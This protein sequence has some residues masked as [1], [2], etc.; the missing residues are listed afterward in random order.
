MYDYDF[1]VQAWSKF[2]VDFDDDM[3]SFNGP[4]LTYSGRALETMDYKLYKWPGHGLADEV[5]SYQ[6]VEGEYMKANEY[7]AMI[8]DPSDFMLRTILPRHF[9][10]AQGLQKFVS[11]TSVYGRPLNTIHPFALP[12]VRATFQ[13]FIDAGLEWEKWQKYVF[14]LMRDASSAATATA[15]TSV[16]KRAAFLL[17]DGSVVGMDGSTKLTTPFTISQ[18]LY[19]VIWHRN[20]LGIMSANAVTQTGGIYT[21]DFTNSSAKA[22]GG[23][24]AQKQLATGIWG[25]VAGDGNG[26]KFVNT[27]DKSAVW[28]IS[29]GNGGY[30]SG[31]YN[32]NSQVN[33]QD[34]NDKWL[35]NTT[36]QSQVPN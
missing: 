4:A 18:N 19:V 36:Y 22:Y 2:I 9:G 29:V 12:E 14:G 7:E 32:M 1:L 23:T 21:Y 13:A 30:L 26:D 27:T 34:K 17:S 25:M 3:D 35:L 8:N 28:G 16:R 11:M 31:D 15:V 6:F 33:N 10:A 5:S 24:A 20:H